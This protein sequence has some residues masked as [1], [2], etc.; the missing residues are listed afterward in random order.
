MKFSHLII[1]A[2]LIKSLQ[3]YH[4]HNKVI[5]AVIRLLVTEKSVAPMH[6]SIFFLSYVLA[7][8]SWLAPGVP[9][10]L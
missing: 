10:V 7:L 3:A 1:T 8:R 5:T 9:Y 6:V 2:R 4:F